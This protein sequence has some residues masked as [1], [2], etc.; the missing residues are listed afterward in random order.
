MSTYLSSELRKG[1]LEAD[2]HRCAYC[3]TTQFNSGFPM[4][5]DHIVPRSRGGP[6][7]FENI[8]FACHRC[9]EFKMDVI[10]KEDPLTGEFIRLFHPRQDQWQEHFV[11]DA[12]GIRIQ[13]RTAVGRVTILA[14]RM[15]NEV[16]VQARKNWAS[17]GWHPPEQ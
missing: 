14:L 5:V 6:T 8:C 17:A 4:V 13:G 16:I 12:A 9:N 2:D 10:Q 3:Q 7:E 15:N 1:L 11:W